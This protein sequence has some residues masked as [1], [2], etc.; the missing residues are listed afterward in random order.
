LNVSVVGAGRVGTAVAVLLGRAGHRVVAVSGRGPTRA[1]AAAYLP[2]VPVV[3]PAD[4]AR[5]AE[6]VFFGVPD[7]VIERSV[8][9]VAS[10]GAFHPGQWAVHLSGATRLH[11]L[12]AAR[13][14]G[15]GRLAIHPLQTVPDVPGAIERIP[16]STIA[17]TADD[18]AGYFLGEKLAA[19]MLGEPFR[20]R[21]EMRPAYHAA[22]VFASNHLVANSVIALE[23]FEAAGVPDPVSAMLPLQRATL[24]NI[25]RLGAAQ[26]LTGPAARG[27]AGTLELNLAAIKDVDPSAINAYVA[28]ARLALDISEGEGRLAPGGRAAVEE[29]LD[30]WS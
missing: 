14:G 27:D 22:A 28:M 15:A 17:V 2:G 19:D 16:G 9:E 24:D 26:A 30:R 6:V 11:V 7:D 3:D 29:V 13:A 20:L 12:D 10:A 18:E 4:A 25:A 5:D 23:L 8:L 1:R 21:D